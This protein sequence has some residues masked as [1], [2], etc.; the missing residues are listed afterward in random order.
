MCTASLFDFGFIVAQH[1]TVTWKEQHLC[2]VDGFWSPIGSPFREAIGHQ[3]TN[4]F[5]SASIDSF[6]CPP[7]A[8]CY[9]GPLS[10]ITTHKTK[11]S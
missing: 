6:T 3:E 5:Q 1:Q 8:D 2:P 10:N 4:F 7:M 11:N 9:A